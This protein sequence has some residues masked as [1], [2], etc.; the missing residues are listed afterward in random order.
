MTPERHEQICDLLYQALAL[1][2][3]Q[4]ESFLS[5]AC[6]SDPSLRREVDSLL[7]SSDD[8]RA[9][10]LQSSTLRLA[11]EPGIKL[12]DYEVESLLGKGGMGEVYRARDLRLAREVAIKVLPTYRLADQKQLGRFEQEARAAAALNHPN[13]LAVFQLG[14]H[15][16]VPYLVSELLQGETLR[17]QIRRGSIAQHQAVGFAIQIGRGLAAAHDKGIVHRDLKPENLFVT[18]DGQVKI[19]DFGLAKLTQSSLKQNP[20]T[21]G[22]V[23]MGTLG[24]MSPEQARGQSSDARSDIFA[25]GVVLY[26]MLTGRHAFQ[27]DTAADTMSAILND[28]PPAISKTAPNFPPALQR[29]VRRCLEKRPEE[30]FQRASDVV[31]ELESLPTVQG[32]SMLKV[33][34][35]A[36]AVAAVVVMVF[37]QKKT[38]TYFVQEIIT[39]QSPPSKT[40]PPLAE[41]KL[42]SNLSD[43]PVTAAAISRDG[44]YVAYTDKSKNAHYLLVD[45]G[46]VRPLSLD[47][48]YE[49]TDWFPDGVHLLVKHLGGRPGLWKFSTWDSRLQKLW[50]GPMDSTSNGPV[51]D[52]AVSPDGSRIAFIGGDDLR[53]IW[54]MGADGEEPHKILELGAPDSLFNIAWSPTGRRLAYIRLRGTVAEHESVIETCDLTGHSVSAVLSEPKLMGRDGVA[55]ISWLADGR[56]VYSISAKLLDEYNLWS[57]MVNPETGGHIGSPEPLTDW[58]DLAAPGFQS[59]ADGK[60]MIVRKRHS[61]DAIYVGALPSEPRG[62]NVKRLMADSWRNT[63]KSWTKDS[64][65]ILF[66][67]KRNGRWTICKQDTNADMPVTLIAGTENYRDP[68]PSVTG[69]LLYNAFASPDDGTGGGKWRLMS[70]PMDGGPRSVLMSGPLFYTYDCASRGSASCVVADLKD[71]QLIFSSLDPD[72][73]RGKGGELA[74]VTYHA[75]DMPHWALSP[76]GTRIAMVETGGE[77]SEI[78]ILNLEDRKI[79]L[80]PV[81]GW[82]WKY[83]TDIGWAA[84]GKRLFAITASES[85][86]ALISIDPA[87]R[88]AILHEVDPGQAWLGLPIAS[89][90]GRFLAFTKRTYVSDLVMLENF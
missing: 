79:T 24:Y 84:D 13:I 31:R 3:K 30:R 28:D 47:S 50:E 40:K 32:R 62:F 58:R 36:L 80:L 5:R 74:R 72:P 6:S 69:R 66:F 88:L 48:S 14:E 39:R 73:E 78:K 59:T 68:V 89:P 35:S 2:A 10:F 71:N 22:G 33:F 83:L 19:L 85:S 44:K 41:R 21:E 51:R 63:A 81:H 86:S 29:L 87:G 16:G 75:G 64:K 15:E 42:T 53:E 17:D 38:L 4:R 55:G 8:V 54:L 34:G 67:S 1:D 60:H 27:R 52:V 25:F 57:V 90:D 61:E 45:S 49:P 20:S 46:D 18:T 56:I 11:L 82:K 37:T 12:G 7:S 70:T 9:N 23:V 65:S 76:D 26:E 77:S 43:N